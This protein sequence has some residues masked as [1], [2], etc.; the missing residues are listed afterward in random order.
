METNLIYMH[1]MDQLA[2]NALVTDIRNDDGKI[3]IIL[4]QTVFY[5]Q[6]GGQPYD[7]GTITSPSKNFLAQEVRFIDGLVHHIGEYAENSEPFSLGDQVECTVDAE[8]RAI[9]TR[10]HSAG[11]LI[12]MA[13]KELN[14]PWKPGKGYHFPNGP[15]VEYEGS[16]SQYD[17]EE[18][19]ASLENKCNEIIARNI[20]TSV[21]FDETKMV[22]QKPLRTVY[23]G[24]FGIGCGGTHVANLSQI[25]KVV[26]RKIK[27]ERGMVKVSY[28]VE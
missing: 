2:C 18:I 16:L 26:V 8:R 28:L 9:N 10:L 7:T 13:L 15:Y 24:A 12:D 21:I 4:D 17:P 11:H 6:G 3:S 25:G 19:R 23:Y 20:E 5:P 22:N 14:V 27:S 1:H